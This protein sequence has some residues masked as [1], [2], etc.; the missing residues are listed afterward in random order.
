MLVKMLFGVLSPFSGKMWM[1][2]SMYEGSF[3][4][5]FMKETILDRRAEGKRPR[6]WV[7]GGRFMMMI[8]YSTYT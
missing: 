2:H 1:N 5:K 3:R 6:P 7:R 8:I 4:Y